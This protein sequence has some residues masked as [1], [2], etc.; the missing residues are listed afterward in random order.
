MQNDTENSDFH[1]RD[2]RMS[3]RQEAELVLRYILRRLDTH[4]ERKL[5]R[6]FV[7]NLDAPWGSGKSFFLKCLKKDMES[8]GYLVAYVNSWENDH[9]EDAMLPILSAIKNLFESVVPVEQR[10]HSHAA[11]RTGGKL[12]VLAAKGI[13]NQFA[14][15][16][17]GEEFVD[18]AVDIASVA[19]ETTSKAIDLLADS[20]VKEIEIRT[21]LVEDFHTQL[22]EV[23]QRLGKNDPKKTQLFIFIDELDRCRPTYAVETLERIKHILTA[24]GTAFII[25]TDTSQLKCSVNQIYGQNFDS[26][27]Y[28]KRFFDRQYELKKPTQID[29]VKERISAWGFTPKFSLPN[30]LG[31]CEEFIAKLVIGFNLTARDTIQSISLLEDFA[32]TWQEN[33]QIEL[34]FLAPLAIIY[35]TRRPLFEA[36]ATRKADVENRTLLASSLDWEIVPQRQSE[37]GGTVPSK[38]FYTIFDLFYKYSG[39]T[40]QE[41]Y[42]TSQQELSDTENWIIGRLTLDL[43][44]IPIR[45][46]GFKFTLLH[47]YFER[48][49]DLGSFK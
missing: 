41:I 30:S 23:I 8:E 43:G 45:D 18:S 11:I 15:K 10:K 21:Q 49:R 19:T 5:A 36:L 7:L 32:V 48:V 6:S 39:K 4:E 24:N 29:L 9:G 20:A 47:T 27:T 16:W 13:V 2:D 33:T 17:I 28:L 12:A 44:G 37:N 26:E 1:W 35:Q 46:F 3:R 34:A 38:K 14:K 42:K 31:N 25:A 40:L 22:S